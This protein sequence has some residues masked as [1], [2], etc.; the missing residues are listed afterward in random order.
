M[1]DE[2][3]VMISSKNQ[4]VVISNKAGNHS[5]FKVIIVVYSSFIIHLSFFII[6][7]S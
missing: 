5:N 6:Y 3:L 2:L 4:L 1:N 7:H